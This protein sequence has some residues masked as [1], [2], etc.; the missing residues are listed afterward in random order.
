MKKIIVLITI[1][2]SSFAYSQTEKDTTNTIE[3]DQVVINS[4]RFGKSK[5]NKKIR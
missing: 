1:V 2:V 3:L 4:Q 5:M